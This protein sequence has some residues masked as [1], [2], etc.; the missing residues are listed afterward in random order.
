M[1]F[2]GM[3]WFFRKRKKLK[4]EMTQEQAENLIDFLEAEFVQGIGGDK[5]LIHSSYVRNIHKVI[6]KLKEMVGDK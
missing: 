1:M 4:L 2:S 6:E 3:W 5:D